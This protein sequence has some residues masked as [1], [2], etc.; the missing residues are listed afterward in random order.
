MSS[1]CDDDRRVKSEY[2]EFPP[3]QP[4]ARPPTDRTVEMMGSTS[5]K[6]L[7][8]WQIGDG[9]GHVSKLRFIGEALKARGVTCTAALTRLEHA[10]EIRHVADRIHSAPPLPYFHHLRIERGEQPAAT[11]GEFLGDL[12]FASPHIIAEHVLFWRKLIEVDRPDI[13]IGEQA[14]ST[15]LAARSLGIPVVALGTTY[16]LPPTTMAAF[17]VLLEEYHERKWSE[18]QMCD[19]I[20]SV[21]VRLGVRPLTRLS[22]VY[23]AD[24]ALPVGLRMLDPYAGARIEPRLPP[25]APDVAAHETAWRQRH[26]V[27]V[28]L[29]AGFRPDRSILDFVQRVKL[30][31]RIYMANGNPQMAARLRAR[32]AIV[33]DEPVVP[34]TIARRSRLMFHSGNMGTM[35][36]GI[37]AGIPQISVPQQ[38]EQ[39]YH[40]RCL[41]RTGAATTLGWGERSGAIFADRVASL[42]E[43]DRTHLSALALAQQMQGEFDGDTG[44]ISAQK[45]ID[46][47]N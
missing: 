20:N 9:R 45:I 37:K 30:P 22:E 11:Y 8:A 34:A 35:C 17:P 3:G 29:S 32:G 5:K 44:Q 27:F 24:A 41:E 43:D 21:V 33:E 10:D 31:L 26:E 1:F 46:L 2:S 4:S 7:L 28:Y 47:V 39:M 40:A 25:N 14:P 12:G 16:T 19:A 6:A 36:L 23:T 18:G 38:L 42:Y 15:L 13:V